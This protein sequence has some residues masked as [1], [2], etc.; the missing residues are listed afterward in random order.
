MDPLAVLLESRGIRLTVAVY[1][2]KLQILKGDIDSVQ[3]NF[4]EAVGG[5]QRR[6]LPES[7]QSFF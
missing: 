2:W 6:G 7:I 5:R 1:P 4:L 3:V